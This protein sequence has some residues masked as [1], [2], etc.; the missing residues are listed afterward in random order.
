MTDEQREDLK[1]SF[2]TAIRATGF[3]TEVRSSVSSTKVTALCRIL[4]ETGKIWDGERGL[5]AH[6]L[7]GEQDWTSFIGKQYLLRGKEKNSGA[8][9]YGWC[10]SITSDNLPRAVEDFCGLIYEF[11]GRATGQQV[12]S[13]EKLEVLHL[14]EGTETLVPLRSSP[15][16][17][18]PSGSGKGMALGGAT[19]VR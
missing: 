3:L 18:T 17:N 4:P 16:R 10:I 9:V 1:R 6:L 5:I 2:L 7:R 8:L 12:R 15:Q 13:S 11:V 19:P 14:A